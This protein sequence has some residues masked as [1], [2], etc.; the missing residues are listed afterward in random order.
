MR[1]RERSDR[2]YRRV[3]G[4]SLVASAL[5]HAAVLAWRAKGPADDIAVAVSE[6]RERPLDD[7]E[8]RLARNEL[9]LLAIQPAAAD[10]VPPPVVTART[11]SVAE[12]VSP[13]A[14]AA[15]ADPPP[16]A[17]G[18]P[19]QDEIAPAADLAEPPPA[20]ASLAEAEPAAEVVPDTLFV[21][22]PA[23]SLVPVAASAEETVT[24]DAAPPAAAPASAPASG[25][26]STVPTYTPGSVGRAK[27]QWI[28][29]STEER[30]G[31]IRVKVRG[32]GGCGSPSDPFW[33]ANSNL[34]C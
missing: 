8:H 28:G 30:P 32:L 22:V 11:P 2:Q 20:V 26:T 25:R 33:T 18:P 21:E 7:V 29:D 12:T 27:G 31:G 19:E 1:R 34:R 17:P 5:L 3:L 23:S 24:A 9:R 16:S 4:V 6:A 14:S 15:P 13:P 10:V